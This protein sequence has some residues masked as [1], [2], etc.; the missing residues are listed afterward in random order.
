MG[1][2][3]VG[4]DRSTVAEHRGRG[5]H[6]VALLVAVRA[7]LV[8]LNGERRRLVSHC[9]GIVGMERSLCCVVGKVGLLTAFTQHRGTAGIARGEQRIL[10]R[11]LPVGEVDAEGL[12]LVKL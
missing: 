1:E 2:T 6:Q 3:K 8:R 7:R 4:S 9:K 11:G 12:A 5:V 10:D